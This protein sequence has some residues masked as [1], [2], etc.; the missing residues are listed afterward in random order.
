MD[1]PAFNLCG[2]LVPRRIMRFLLDNLFTGKKDI[3]KS[4]MTWLKCAMV[5]LPTW[6]HTLSN[7][8]S[9]SP[10]S[11]VHIYWIFALAERVPD[12][13]SVILKFCMNNKNSSSSPLPNKAI[14]K[15]YISDFSNVGS[16]HNL[17]CTQYC[18][19]FVSFLLLSN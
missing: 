4:K 10:H 16:I 5:V 15:S 8:F 13:W 17:I 1:H 7:C 14:L 18:F 12:Y 3:P 19:A 2:F 6:E 9:A 11:R